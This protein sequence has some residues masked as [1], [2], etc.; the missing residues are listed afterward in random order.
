MA[1]AVTREHWVGGEIKKQAYFSERRLCAKIQ[2]LLEEQVPGPAPGCFVNKSFTRDF[3][4]PEDRV[5]V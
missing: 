5:F 4:L 2:V 3:E 1:A